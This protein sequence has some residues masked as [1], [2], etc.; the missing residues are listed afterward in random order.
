M[1]QDHATA[2]HP[3]RQ[4]ETPSQEKKKMVNKFY[5]MCFLLQF[6]KKKR[7]LDKTADV[8]LAVTVNCHPSVASL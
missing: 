1:S 5:V 6:L 8:P 3:G 2:L 7:R 4:S